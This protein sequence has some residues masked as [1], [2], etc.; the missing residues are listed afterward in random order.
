[1]SDLRKDFIRMSIVHIL[2]NALKEPFLGRIAVKKICVVLT[3]MRSSATNT[4]LVF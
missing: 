1:M 2:L 3:Q 4:N